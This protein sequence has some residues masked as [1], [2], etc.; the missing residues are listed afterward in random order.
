MINAHSVRWNEVGD[1]NRRW[2]GRV[3]HA[4]AERDVLGRGRKASEVAVGLGLAVAVGLGV[5]VVSTSAAAD[6]DSPAVPGLRARVPMTPRATRTPTTA[7]TMGSPVV[8]RQVGARQ[9]VARQVGVPADLLQRSRLLSSSRTRRCRR[10][11]TRIGA[12]PRTVGTTQQPSF[13][14]LGVLGTTPKDPR[15]H[16]RISDSNTEE[17]VAEDE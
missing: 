8:A 15:L 14:P 13:S 9:V 6:G 5:G 17:G 1:G 7:R 2:S 3:G 10:T 12:A 4:F 16:P 11:G